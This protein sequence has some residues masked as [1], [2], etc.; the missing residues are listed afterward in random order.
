MIRQ[1]ERESAPMRSTTR[2]DDIDD[3]P[4]AAA[5]EALRELLE[6]LGSAGGG[7]AAGVVEELQELRGCTLA[8][9]DEQSRLVGLAAELEQL[10]RSRAPAPVAPA[11]E[12]LR[13]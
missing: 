8:R 10:S 9:G 7:S 12:S 1:L 3:L 6:L 11:D 4:L 2:G 13:A 5:C